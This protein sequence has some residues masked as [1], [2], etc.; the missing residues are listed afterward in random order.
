MHLTFRLRKDSFKFIL[1]VPGIE[2]HVLHYAASCKVYS[3]STHFTVNT[4]P[5]QILQ[6]NF[7]MTK[8]VVHVCLTW[9]Y[10]DT[11]ASPVH[12]LEM[13]ASVN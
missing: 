11:L 12:V 4:V 3:F 7:S 6:S 5:W 1:L 2:N 13:A 8:F 9:P 10:I